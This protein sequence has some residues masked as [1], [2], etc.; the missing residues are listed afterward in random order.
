MHTSRSN[1]LLWVMLVSIGGWTLDGR[2]QAA[3]TVGQIT[4]VSHVDVIP[5]EYKPQSEEKAAALFRAETTATQ[6]D[7]GYISYVVLRQVDGGNHFTIIESWAD[8]STYAA[9]A[10]SEHTIS[11]RR[12]ILEYLG[13]P[14]DARVHQVFK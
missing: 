12:N 13:S 14:F 3:A 4:V 11:F 8:S 1:S 2:V 10:A 5:D 7:K 6:R 9:H